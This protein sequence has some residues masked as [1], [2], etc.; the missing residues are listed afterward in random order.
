MEL[1]KNMGKTKDVAIPNEEFTLDSVYR[2][3]GVTK[4]R[5]YDFFRSNYHQLGQIFIT[6][7][8]DDV[9][10]DKSKRLN[11]IIRISQVKYFF[12]KKEILILTIDLDFFD[13]GNLKYVSILFNHEGGGVFT[14]ELYNELLVFVDKLMKEIF[15]MNRDKKLE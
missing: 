4:S 8:F 5:L 12:F 3:L 14:Q 11:Y 1:V 7:S 9:D 6:D 15:N 2:K 10:W 13:N